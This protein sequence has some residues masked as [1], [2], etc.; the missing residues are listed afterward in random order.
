MQKFRSTLAFAT[1]AVLLVGLALAQIGAFIYRV[2]RSGGVVVLGNDSDGSVRIRIIDP[3]P[4]AARQKDFG[5]SILIIGMIMTSL[6]V[7][8]VTWYVVRGVIKTVQGGADRGHPR[9][10]L[11]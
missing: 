10:P 9:I 11:T 7:L 4:E 6:G 1:V 2:N 3:D 8:G 5:K